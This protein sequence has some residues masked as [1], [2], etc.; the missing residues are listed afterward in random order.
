MRERKATEIENECQ[1]EPENLWTQ[2]AKEKSLLA[3][4]Q[5]KYCEINLIKKSNN[6]D[7]INL[8]RINYDEH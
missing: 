2:K 3:G 5:K 4:R 8:R 6:Q 7:L 1:F